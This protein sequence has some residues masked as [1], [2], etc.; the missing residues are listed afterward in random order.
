MVKEYQICLSDNCVGT[1]TVETQGLYYVIRCRCVFN[2]PPQ[3]RI[4]VENEATREDLGICVPTNGAFGLEKRIP[5]KRIGDGELIFSCVPKHNDV[6]T[7]FIPVLPEAPFS[8]IKMLKNACFAVR[9][10]QVGILLKK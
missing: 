10:G 4:I 8:H 1:A 6:N 2:G 7:Q 5:I 9:D 3:Y